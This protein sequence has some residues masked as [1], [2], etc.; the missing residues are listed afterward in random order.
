MAHAYE[1]NEENINAIAQEIYDRT[2][3]EIRDW[4]IE[5]YA[6]GEKRVIVFGV[7]INGVYHPWANMRDDYFYEHY[8]WIDK[9]RT[10]K[11]CMA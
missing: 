7:T 9:T 10:N 1:L 4:L 5:A 2:S 6:L 8:D 3:R 11:I